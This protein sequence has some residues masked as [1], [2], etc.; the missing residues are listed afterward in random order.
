[1]NQLNKI[2]FLNRQILIEIESQTELS[3]ISW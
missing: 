3:V 2:S 1:M